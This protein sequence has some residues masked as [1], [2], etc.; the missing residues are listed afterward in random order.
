[1]SR[2]FVTSRS[3]SSG[4][5]DLVQRLADAGHDV[6]RGPADHDL[7]RLT[8]QLADAAAWIAG[9]A[10]VTA[11]HLELAPQLRVLA[12]YGVGYDAVDI[13]AAAAAGVVVTNTPG[14]NS[15][16]VADHAVALM[17][18]ALRHVSAGDR[19]VR[20]G[21]W[22][23]RRGREL[24]SQTVGIVGFGRIGRLVAQRLVGF[25]S[26]VVVDDP[27]VP[28]DVV[29]AAGATR[30]VGRD[31][32]RQCE[33][34]TVH[35][36]GGGVVVDADW[37]LAART[38]MTVV[39]TARA[40][41]VDELAVA[42]ALRTGVVGAYAADT[43]TGDVAGQTGHQSPL[44]AP[45][46]ADRVVVTPHLGAQTV[47]AIDAMGSMAVNDVIAVLSGLPPVHAVPLPGHALNPLE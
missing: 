20:S 3:F 24:G 17:L 30:A 38:G 27:W 5:V 16:A 37:L 6:V 21:D 9:T 45:D 43:L 10:S 46:L 29:A 26:P 34:V 12:R 11:A 23:A 28:D 19:A 42:A 25:G 44:L 1:M 15:S 33:V 13:A 41:L 14:A 31:L 8:P 2:V 39:N 40:D 18:A 32:A 4:D 35:R 36:P 47:E 7:S 22:S